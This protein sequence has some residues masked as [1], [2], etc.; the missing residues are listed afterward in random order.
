L[1][2][3]FSFLNSKR[4][5]RKRIYEKKPA[6]KKGEGGSVESYRISK[7]WKKKGGNGWSSRRK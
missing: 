4:I 3:L 6:T 2:I 7:P 5:K 1:I